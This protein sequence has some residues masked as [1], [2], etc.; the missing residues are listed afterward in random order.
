MEPSR[1]LIKSIKWYL[2]DIIF[3]EA[4]LGCKNRGESLCNQCILKIRNTERETDKN[5]MA[6]YDYRDPLIKKAIWDLKYH[7]RLNLGK[8][9]GAM[10]YEFFLEEIANMEAYTKGQSI[11]VIPVPLSRHREKER[12]YNQA[13]IIAYGLS[14]SGEKGLF[15]LNNNIVVKKFDTKPQAK[16]ANRRERLL[17]VK[18]IFEIR[19]NKTVKGRTIL[20]I[21]DVTTTGGTINEIIKILKKGGAKKVVGFALAH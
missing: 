19:K 3:P 13:Q 8:K 5:I 2:L 9:L 11:L 12:G 4:C 10:L 7:H 18:N 6:V 16:I 20:V 14:S 21:D 1:N 15:E 17:N